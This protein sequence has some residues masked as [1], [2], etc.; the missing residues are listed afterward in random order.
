MLCFLLIGVVSQMNTA[1]FG[2]CLFSGCATAA[3]FRQADAEDIAGITALGAY[4]Y[5]CAQNASAH[6]V[7]HG[8]PKH[9]QQ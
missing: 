3:W 1:G 8:C 6:S 2:M 4:R 9:Q 5:G 7:D